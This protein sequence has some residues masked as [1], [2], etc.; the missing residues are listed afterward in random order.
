M[1]LV[2]LRRIHGRRRHAA[3][4][5]RLIAVVLKVELLLLLAVMDAL[6]NLWAHERAFC[7]DSLQRYHMIQVNG[8]QSARVAGELS[9][10]A[11]KGAIVDLRALAYRVVCECATHHLFGGLFWWSIWQGGNNVLQRPVEA[12]SGDE[13]VVQKAA[14][15]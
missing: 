15:R 8:A 12:R 1:F 7:H 5:V 6:D 2:V 10:A 3:G 13:G 14:S 9:K 4:R 11:Y